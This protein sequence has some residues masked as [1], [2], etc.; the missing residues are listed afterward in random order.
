MKRNALTYRAV[1]RL[2]RAAIFAVRGAKKLEIRPTA[3]ADTPTAAPRLERL[4]NFRRYS[5]GCDAGKKKGFN[6]DRKENYVSITDFITGQ[7]KY[8]F[9]CG[10]CG[11]IFYADKPTFENINRAVEQGLDNSFLCEN[12]R[13]RDEEAADE[14]R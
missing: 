8:E 7:N 3:V 14:T 10:K 2:K 13:R 4:R 9:S 5:E 6:A 1:V 12:C 11:K